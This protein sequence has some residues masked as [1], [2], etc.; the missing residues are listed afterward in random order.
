MKKMNIEKNKL[1]QKILAEEL[2]KQVKLYE[3]SEVTIWKTLSEKARE[4]VLLSLDPKY[5]DDLAEEYTNSNWDEIPS[6]VQ[7]MISKVFQDIN[8]VYVKANIARL[9]MKYQDKLSNIEINGSKFEYL[10]NTIRNGSPSPWAI[11]SAITELINIHAING[12]TDPELTRK[13]KE[14]LS[15]PNNSDGSNINGPRGFS[16]PDW[17]GSY[18]GD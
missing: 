15:R 10:I 4:S 14:Q 18:K 13:P 7:P 11:V 16:N 17:R 12:F 2:N 6:D 1:F 5:G 9:Y 8:N 3:S